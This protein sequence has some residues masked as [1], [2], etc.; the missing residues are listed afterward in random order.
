VRGPKG[1]TIDGADWRRPNATALVTSDSLKIAK[2]PVGHA[3]LMVFQSD[4]E[5]EAHPSISDIVSDRD[6]LQ[7]A[8]R[9]AVICSVA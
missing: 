2:R 3:V 8:M 6:R 9:Q 1:C 4:S 5:G 7:I